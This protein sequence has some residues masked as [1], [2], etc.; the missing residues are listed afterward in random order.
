VLEHAQVGKHGRD[1]E[2]ADEAEPG[3]VGRLAARDVAALEADPA[4]GRR[5]EVGQEIEARRLPRAVGPDEGVNGA[6]P[7]AQVHILDGD[8]PAKLF[9][10]PMCLEDGVRH[11]FRGWNTASRFSCHARLASSTS[12]EAMQ[13]FWARITSS[14]MVRGSSWN[15]AW[16]KR[17]ACAEAVG[18]AWR[19]LSMMS[20][21]APSV[22]PGAH[23]Q[24][25]S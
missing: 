5:Q 4:A 17:L 23:T 19:T 11:R 2:R 24:L 16:S 15:E 9:G 3:D 13:S 21:S 10:Q 8:E 14:T 25:T 18:A 7:H 1:L 6:T 22:A 12:H 20:R